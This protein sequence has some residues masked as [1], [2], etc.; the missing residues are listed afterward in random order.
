MT[1]SGLILFL[2]LVL[3]IAIFRYQNSVRNLQSLQTSY[4]QEILKSQL[5]MQHQTL[6]HVGRELH[7]NIGQLL[8]V[9]R[10]NLNVLEE[11]VG[12]AEILNYILQTNEVVDQ[13]INALRALSKSLDGNIVQDFG[14]EESISHELQR[15][16]K[17]KKFETEIT[18][19]GNRY[20]LEREREIILFRI[21]QEILNN[22]LKHS[23]AQHLNVHLEYS[24]ENFSVTVSD[25]GIGFDISVI[26]NADLDQSGSGLRNI[27]RRIELI[28][29]NCEL[30]SKIGKGTTI[31]L[32]INRL[33]ENKEQNSIS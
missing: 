3:I 23:Q 11:S 5:E 24:P 13:S 9:A 7:D 6:Q 29:G 2:A 8:S 10:I 18:V 26:K 17:T 27:S 4:Q 15:I 20:T 33:I 14:L 12:D 32:H 28:G 22:A 31:N 19:N 30:V 25:D 16:R 21:I 1:F